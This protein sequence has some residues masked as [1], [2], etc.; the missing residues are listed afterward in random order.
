M[1]LPPVLYLRRRVR[2]VVDPRREDDRHHDLDPDLVPSLVLAREGTVVLEKG[3]DVGGRRS[4]T[5]ARIGKVV[6]EKGVGD[7]LLREGSDSIQ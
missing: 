5:F 7:H 4:N 6:E 3:K 2:D 1:P